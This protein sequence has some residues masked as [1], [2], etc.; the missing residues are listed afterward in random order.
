M[1][2][3]ALHLALAA[4]ATRRPLF[5]SEADFQHELA[6]EIRARGLGRGVRLERPFDL[7]ERLNVDLVVLGDV[8]VVALELKY[9]P[10]A[11]AGEIDGEPFLLKNRGAQDLGRYD[12]WKD[13]SR[14]EQLKAAGLIQWGAAVAVTN[15]PAYWSAVRP[16][17][18][19][20]AFRLQDGTRV[21]G[22]LAWPRR[23]GTTRGRES[24]IALA[25]GHDI[26]WRPFGA[27]AAWGEPRLLTLV[28]GAD[29]G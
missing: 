26:A 5:H 16:G 17:T 11:W 24:D 6:W 10:R 2:P 14:I 21:E 19:A 18:M 15:D 27:S 25:R 1:T 23:S 13:V 20:E 12:Y 3:T 7:A 29:A 22:T 8:G 28:V 9:W 4:L